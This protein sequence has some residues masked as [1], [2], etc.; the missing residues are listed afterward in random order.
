MLVK[1]EACPAPAE[2]MALELGGKD[3]ACLLAWQRHTSP[4]CQ[5]AL[6][7]VKRARSKV[8]QKKGRR[9]RGRGRGK[10]V[11]QMGWPRGKGDKGVT[12]KVQSGKTR[13]RGDDEDS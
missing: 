8:H 9:R 2:A 4:L 1:Q 12:L 6:V 3:V 5:R 7:N 11:R 13:L 10:G